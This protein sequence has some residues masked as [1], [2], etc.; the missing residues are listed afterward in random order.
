[1][2]PRPIN[3]VLDTA[4]EELI[5]RKRPNIEDEALIETLN[6]NRIKNCEVLIQ[7][8]LVR[9]KGNSNDSKL[10]TQEIFNA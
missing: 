1:M 10:F 2:F 7:T 8:L 6:P 3:P 5:H 9:S 4:A